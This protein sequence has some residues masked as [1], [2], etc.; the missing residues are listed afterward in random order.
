MC[1]APFAMPD[2]AREELFACQSSQAVANDYAF[3]LRRYSRFQPL[4]LRTVAESVELAKT[5]PYGSCSAGDLLLTSH[6]SDPF[7]NNIMLIVGVSL[8]V[9]LLQCED[10][11]RW[12]PEC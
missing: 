5:I 10:Y 6:A 3:S 12:I 8:R 1:F 2:V 4:A 7:R 11:A 9:S